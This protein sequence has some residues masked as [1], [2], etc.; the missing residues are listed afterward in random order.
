MTIFLNFTIQL[1]G[2]AKILNSLTGLPF[3]LA[4]LLAGGVILFYLYIGGF[5]AVV[6]TDIVQFVA[7]ITLFFVLGVFLFSNFTFEATQWDLLSAGPKLIIP[8]I[9]VGILFPFSAPDLWQRT[10]AAKSVRSLKRTFAIT[11]ALYITF[12]FLLSLIAIIIRLKLPSIEADIA[13]VEGFTYL[14]PSGLLGAG[15][16]ALFAAIMSS[17][18]SY[19][20]IS[21]G[22]L[23]HDIF[24]RKQGRSIKMLKV[25]IMIV[26]LLGVVAAISFKSIL[27]ASFLLGGL[28]M[29]MSVIVFATWIKK[30]MRA[31]TLN[32]SVLIG[33]LIT[34]VASPIVGMTPMLIVVGVVGGL[35]GLVIGFA[36]SKIV[37]WKDIS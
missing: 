5:R 9:L 8:L 22:I 13:L 4:V 33:L 36:V 19:A 34:I 37:Y 29:V 3:I 31:M 11:T 23:M 17:A 18:D 24:P 35:I 16:V 21:A 14:L 6:K 2:G 1:I 30:R 20:F 28:F 27:D 25:G 15:L 7:I 10:L 12:G 32:I 26:M